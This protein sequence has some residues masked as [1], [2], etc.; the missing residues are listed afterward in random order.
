[1]SFIAVSCV[2]EVSGT[3]PSEMDGEAVLTK[4]ANSPENS[5]DDRI[6][7]CLSEDAVALVEGGQ[8]EPADFIDGGLDCV[9]VSP[10]LSV[11]PANEAVARKYD[12]H[13]WFV[14][15]F[16]NAS[17]TVAAR[18]LSALPEVDKIEFETR[19]SHGS[20][21][22]SS[23]WRPTLSQLSSS[24]ALPF[25]DP[26]LVDQWHYINTG[27]SLVATTAK[28]GA[29]IAVKDVWKLT[30]GDSR[31][32]VAVL[33]GPVKYDHPDIAANMW[34]NSK[35]IDGNGIDD[36]GNGLVDD[37]HGYNFEGNGPIN[38]NVSGES[39][40]GTHVA[41]TVGAV[42][43]NGLGVCGVAGGTGKG[44]GVR[45]MSC[46][47]FEG[48]KASLVSTSTASSFVYAADNGASVA[49][50]SFGYE[51]VYYK[52][53]K[54][55]ADLYP[56][57]YAAIQYFMDPANNNSDILDRNIVIFASGNEGEAY[58][59]YPGALENCVS[60]TA[61][62]PDY[63][64]AYYTNYGPGC[65]IAAPGG[66]MYVGAYAV[67]YDNMAYD[68]TDNKS[69]VLSLGLKNDYAY[70]QG[71]SMACPHVTGV[72]ALGLAYCYKIGK[73]FT[74]DEFISM[75]LTSVNDIDAT[76]TAGSK[77]AG[78][79]GETMELGIFR[80]KMGTGAID[81]WKF[82][83]A[84]EGTPCIVAKVGES[85]R[86]DISSYFG[87]SASNLTYL[88]VECDAASKEALG[89]TATPEIKYGKLS[90]NPG[91]VGSGKVTVR[92]I[93]GGETVG[94]TSSIGGMEISR[95]ISVIARHVKSSN[96]GWM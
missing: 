22:V 40:H 21:C 70:M 55:Y 3:L 49:Q 50:C 43:G 28:E 8:A 84:I 29:D 32:I 79:A 77:P 18:A 7:V 4:V 39:G 19:I 20:D 36:D 85:Q 2:D 23:S 37:Y 9:S 48:G 1:M 56:A 57:E 63:L 38:W 59:S 11:K 87:G 80:K 30:G 34:V 44:D 64:P 47:I 14:V 74:A 90:I 16:E 53:D 68:L 24:S 86:L 81:A 93:A 26:M 78:F 96:G 33:D 25:D 17:K 67:D 13:R 5:S 31:I 88:G 35:E 94:G 45:I 65:N 73:K 54:E 71:T 82:L 51:K 72:A 27:S 92:A 58:S 61:L 95:E 10:L 76:L 42:N 75:L 60:V 62:G 15:N 66:D 91:K 46:Q 89:L 83:M 12:L 6:L 52:S 41:G 69:R